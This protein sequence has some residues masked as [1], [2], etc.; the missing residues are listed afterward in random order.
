MKF[1]NIKTNY[2]NINL[3]LCIF[4]LIFLYTG[5]TNS[6][7]IKDQ[8]IEKVIKSFLLNNPEL[9]IST[10][11]N[12]KIKKAKQ[13]HKN[14]IKL[15]EKI[16]N[17]GIY[18]KISDITIY[19]FFD[20]NCGYCKSVLKVVQDTL[21]E[22]KNINFVFV[23]FPILSQQS[24]TA[25]IAALASKK[26]GLYNEFHISLMNLRGKINEEE[27]FKTAINVGLNIEKLKLEMS[28]P[29]IKNQLKKNSE[30]AKLL[31]LNG[32]PVF[33]IGDIIF[34]GAI[35]KNRL[36]KIIKNYRKS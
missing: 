26:Q 27:I 22:D 16:D 23:E 13:K 9:I 3:I 30:I 25:A 33:I 1:I 35:D 10:L 18:Q 36:K 2:T 31:G 14:A 7:E 34:P 12:H 32:T 20:Y 6:H 4:A 11:E 21:S 24:Y 28:N 15:L 29:E 17:P 19:E 5:P 8:K